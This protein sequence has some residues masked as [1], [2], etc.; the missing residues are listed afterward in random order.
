MLTVS[1]EIGTYTKTLFPDISID[2]SIRILIEKEFIRRKATYQ[3]T[4][5]IFERKYHTSFN[6]FK[7]NEIVKK[8]NYSFEVENDYIDWEMEKVIISPL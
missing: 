1:D 7:Q 5:R 6:E 2:Q 8:N 3:H 4:I